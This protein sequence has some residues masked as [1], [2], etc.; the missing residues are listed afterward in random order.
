[1]IVAITMLME[2]HWKLFC[3]EL[4]MVTVTDGFLRLIHRCWKHWLSIQR[5]TRRSL[6]ER[7]ALRSI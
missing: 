7:E 1:M 2:P 6:A 3:A 4:H 5:N